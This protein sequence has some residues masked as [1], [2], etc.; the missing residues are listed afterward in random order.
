MKKLITTLTVALV[1]FLN[2]STAFADS[3]IYTPYNPHKPIDTGLET[4]GI[5]A[6]AL[7]VFT[8]GIALLATVKTLKK[9][10]S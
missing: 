10:L 7:V 6:I 4:A 2:A 5:Y 3:G 1:P 8:L 9:K